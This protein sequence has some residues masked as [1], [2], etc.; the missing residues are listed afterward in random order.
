MTRN[1]GSLASHIA[2]G[3]TKFAR[4]MLIELLDG[5]TL[6]ITDHDRDIEYDLGDGLHTYYADTGI[7][8]SAIQLAVGLEADNFEVAG[9]LTDRLTRAQVLGGRFDMAVVRMFDVRWDDLGAGHVPLMK[10]YITEAKVEGGAFKLEVRSDA[11]RFN[12][13]VGRIITPYCS[14]D[15]GDAQCGYSVESFALTVDTVTD[16]LRLTV[17]GFSGAPPA[18]GYFNSGLIQFTSGDLNGARSTQIFRWTAA[19]RTVILE[20][21]LPDLPSP[22]DALTMFRGCGKTRDECKARNNILNF[23]G[24]PDVPGTDKTMRYPV[25]K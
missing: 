2:S 3:R 21:P 12:Q 14:H 10:G 1:V 18:D 11:D 4:C 16:L 8:P 17:T 6:G 25:P 5:T 24:F 20:A 13:V 23:G 22:G 19:T 7:L 9:P 15:F